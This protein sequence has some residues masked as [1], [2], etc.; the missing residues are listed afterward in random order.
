[1]K[2]MFKG[3]ALFLP[4]IFLAACLSGKA[5][6]VNYTVR[7]A[8]ALKDY[9]VYLLVNDQRSSNDLVGPT[10]LDRGLFEELRGGRF[11]LKVTM[12]GAREVTVTNLS[13]VEAV[14]EAASRRL[15]SQGVSTTDQR[16]AAHLTVEINIDQLNIDLQ[17]S[18]LVA[19]VALDSLI[20]RDQSSV[21]KS[22]AR[23][24]SNRM[25]LIGGAGGATVLSE[26]LSQAL[27]D[28]DF[29]G[30]NRF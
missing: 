17:G 16:A 20:Y 15:Q 9:T 7:S 21:A 11:D 4:L 10:A 25:K 6:E 23:A 24:T 14:R 12:P 1:M 2:K 22:N 3:L 27:N 5:M 18:D 13:V 30:I 8:T 29:G 26:A 28:L 19:S